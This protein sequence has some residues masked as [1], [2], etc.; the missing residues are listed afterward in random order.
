[1]DL[2]AKLSSRKFLITILAIA[3]ALSESDLAPPMQLGI[4]GIVAA[5]YVIAEA[6][7]D[8]AGTHLVAEGVER[9]LALGRSAAAAGG[10]EAAPPDPSTSQP[11]T[12]T[13]AAPE[14]S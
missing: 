12:P 4:V 6:F 11:A 1:M 2:L 7:V 3:A 5:V 13:T 14:A 8:R 10:T 9:G